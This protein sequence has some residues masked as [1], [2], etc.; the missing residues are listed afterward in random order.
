MSTSF[1]DPSGRVLVTPNQVVRLVR[2]DGLEDLQALMASERIQP[3]IER[4]SLVS[5]TAI[6]RDDLS[7]DARAVFAD[8]AGTL[9]SHPRVPLPSYPYEWSPAMLHAAGEL[10]LDLAFAGLDDGLRLKDGTP[11]NVLFDGPSPVFVDVLSFEQRPP[12]DPVWWAQGQF[13]RTFLLPLLANRVFGTGLDEIF[14]SHADGLTPDELYRMASFLRRLTPPFLGLA[15]LPKWMS[16]WARSTSLFDPIQSTSPEKAAFTL[17]WVLKSQRRQLDRL[18]PKNA[19][20]SHWSSYMTDL[21]YDQDGFAAKEA[22]TRGALD[23]ARPDA[24]LDVG[25]N[26]GHFSILAAKSG[27]SVV[28]IDLDP[29]VVDTLWHHARQESLAI[30]PLVQNLVHPSPATGWR[31]RERPSFLDR[32]QGRFDLVLMLAVV[33][34][35]LVTERIPIEEI[36]EIA[37]HLTKRSLVVEYVA[38]TDPHFALLSR[39]RHHLFSGFSK[40]VFED[41]FNRRF[42]IAQQEKVPGKNRYLYRMERRDGR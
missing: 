5:S 26:T 20:T 16:R 12:S 32:A 39:G 23:A 17:R 29:Q 38:P 2:A 34:H 30:L 6:G 37:A 9:F 10:T 33:H 31:N 13:A 18:R 4:G 3:F 7:G 19:A 28:A 14:L 25:C 15:S 1:R 8:E 21:H 42:S 35:M 22:F 36:V 41:A 11:F 40:D 27:A 24:V